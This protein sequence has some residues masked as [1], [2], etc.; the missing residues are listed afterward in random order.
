MLE[1]FKGQISPDHIMYKFT[2]KQA[3]SMRETRLSRL[4]KERDEMEKERAAQESKLKTQQINKSI[5]RK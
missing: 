5:L 1:I 3:L 2:Y 4:K